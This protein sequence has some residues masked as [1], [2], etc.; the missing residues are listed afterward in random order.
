MNYMLVKSDE[1]QSK[2]RDRAAEKFQIQPSQKR[3]QKNKSREADIRVDPTQLLLI[4]KTFSAEGEEVSQIDF[5]DVTTGST[6]LAFATVADLVPYLQA[7]ELLSKKPLGIL[8]TSPI[9]QELRGSLVISHLRFPA[10]HKITMEPVL[11]NGSHSWQVH[12]A[13][14]SS[15]STYC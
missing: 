3:K 5:A 13:Q 8:T 2:I 15:W 10:H 12:H 7:G 6:G 4:P 14:C 11:L 9:P 1:L